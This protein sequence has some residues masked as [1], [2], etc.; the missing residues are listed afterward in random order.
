MSNYTQCGCFT[1]PDTGYFEP[2]CEMHEQEYVEY[3]EQTKAAK[4]A[5]SG[6]PVVG[7][8]DE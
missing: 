2:C 7:D 8:G 6:E 5:Q 3:L 4:D 1:N